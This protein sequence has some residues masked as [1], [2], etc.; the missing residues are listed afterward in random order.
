LRGIVCL[1]APALILAQEQ[2]GP[3]A[4]R[5]RPETVR[6]FD[7]YVGA[8][9]A[10][11]DALLEKPGS[12]LWADTEEKRARLRKAGV[13]SEPRSGSGERRIKGGLAHDWVGAAFIPGATVAEVLALLQ[14]YDNHS[15]VYAPE[16]IASRTLERDGDDFKARLR[17]F[18]RRVRITVVLDAD[19][20]IRYRRLSGNDWQSR[21]HSTR[22]V[23]IAAPGRPQEREKPPGQDRGFLWRLN[24]YWLFRERDGGVY[25][26][27]EAISLSRSVPAPLE[28]LI[29][30]IIRGL[31]KDALTSTLEATRKHV[32][33]RGRE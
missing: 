18:K 6:E 23:E 29:G 12:F 1:A 22:I 8:A 19:S 7:A 15:K 14:D 4:G 3:P 2:Q 10:R 9:E 5:I 24:S 27:C 30:P 13:I 32:L 31:S 28:P 33:E 25:V 20:D 17:L 16:V 21:S 11:I 26:E